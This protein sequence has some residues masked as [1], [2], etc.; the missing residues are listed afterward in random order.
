MLEELKK[1][2]PRI[3]TSYKS[4]SMICFSFSFYFFSF[5]HYV[6]VDLPPKLTESELHE[7]CGNAIRSISTRFKGI[8]SFKLKV[9]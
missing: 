7:W 4:T 8:A 2:F 1:M 5:T 9:I 3:D 6:K